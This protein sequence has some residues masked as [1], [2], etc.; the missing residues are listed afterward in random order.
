MSNV[1]GAA[2]ELVHRLLF[3]IYKVPSL[4]EL[5][6]VSFNNYLISQSAF[7]FYSR[8]SDLILFIVRRE[9]QLQIQGAFLRPVCAFFSR[10]DMSRSPRA[11]SRAGNARKAR[12]LGIFVRRC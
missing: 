11:A 5:Q 4:Q 8:K 2:Q 10:P 9:C 6:Q 12:V 1:T 3:T 7:Q